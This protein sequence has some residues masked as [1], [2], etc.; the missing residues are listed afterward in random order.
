MKSKRYGKKGWTNDK[1]AVMFVCHFCL[2]LGLIYINCIRRY[3]FRFMQLGVATPK[4]ISSF[5]RARHQWPQEWETASVRMKNVIINS[6]GS[7]TKWS[8]YHFYA[9][10]KANRMATKFKC[11]V[12]IMLSQNAH[13]LIINIL[14][15]LNTFCVRSSTFCCLTFILTWYA[16]HMIPSTKKKK[17]KTWVKTKRFNWFLLSQ[18]IFHFSSSLN[19][20][21]LGEI[22]CYKLKKKNKNDNVKMCSV[23]GESIKSYLLHANTSKKPN[24][25]CLILKIIIT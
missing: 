22:I 20:K 5:I 2:P 9:S 21:K 8:R 11:K 7:H 1:Q 4:T 10:I 23:N 15:I 18:I 24:S 12:K 16:P 25:R 6:W 14:M 13:R 17:N 19:R 3:P